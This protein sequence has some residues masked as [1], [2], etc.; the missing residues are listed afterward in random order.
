MTDMTCWQ[1]RGKKQGCTRF[2]AWVTGEEEVYFTDQGKIGGGV[3]PT[4][5]VK[6]REQYTYTNTSTLPGYYIEYVTKI[7]SNLHFFSW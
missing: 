1:R 4:R 5:K 3:L 7:L 6:K 2:L